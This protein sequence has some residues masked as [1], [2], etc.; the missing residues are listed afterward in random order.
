MGDLVRRFDAWLA[1]GKALRDMIAA[2][3]FEELNHDGDGLDGP[4]QDCTST[5]ALLN[6][7]IDTVRYAARHKAIGRKQGGMWL[8][9]LPL[10]RRHFRRG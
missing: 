4:W 3:E 8:I 9:N 10:A 5:A 1:E 6:V 7:P 2:L